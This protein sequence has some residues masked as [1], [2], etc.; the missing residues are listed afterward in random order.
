MEAAL[1]VATA[2][3]VSASKISKDALLRRFPTAMW[4]ADVAHEHG[5]FAHEHGTAVHEHGTVSTKS[6]I[7]RDVRKSSPDPENAGP[8]EVLP[9][10]CIPRYIRPIRLPYVLYPYTWTLESAASCVYPTVY[11]PNTPYTPSMRPIRPIRGPL[12]VL[13][14]ACIPRYIHILKCPLYIVTFS[15]N[16]TGALIF[17]CLISVGALRRV[18]VYRARV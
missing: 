15:F 12:Q 6:A 5:T 7:F 13:P 16:Y 2:R 17:F 9:P 14:P 11:T 8:L 10:A 4:E 3:A 18:H 1:E